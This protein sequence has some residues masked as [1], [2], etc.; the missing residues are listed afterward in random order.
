MIAPALDELLLRS[1]Q[2]PMLRPALPVL[3]HE[4]RDVLMLRIVVEVVVLG[5]R[6]GVPARLR[7]GRYVVDQL[8][9]AQDAAAVTNGLQVLGTGADHR[10]LL[11]ER[12]NHNTLS[13]SP[14]ICRCSVPGIGP[15]RR[16][17]GR[18][19]LRCAAG[20]T[21]GAGSAIRLDRPN[22]ARPPT[23]SRRPAPRRAGGPRDGAA[24]VRGLLRRPARLA[25]ARPDEDR[26]PSC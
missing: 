2:E 18:S 20:S 1:R 25:R 26:L 10:G 13:P 8:A 12:W 23:R 11:S 15:P 4:R 9:F 7:M 6:L 5:E 19:W 3:V 16:P 17:R 21:R 24:R 22:D 14:S